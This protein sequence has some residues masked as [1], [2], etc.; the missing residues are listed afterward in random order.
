MIFI[1]AALGETNGCGTNSSGQDAGIAFQ[2][3]ARAIQNK[4]GEHRLTACLKI[5][6]SAILA[7]VEPGVSPGK[8]NRRSAV[9]LIK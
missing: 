1:M 9:S 6:A 4:S 5:V 3:G 7:D 8:K 2:N